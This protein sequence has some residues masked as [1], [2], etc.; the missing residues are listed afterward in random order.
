MKKLWMVLLLAAVLTL[1]GC[2]GGTEEEPQAAQPT[3]TV[4]YVPDPDHELV[5]CWVKTGEFEEGADYVE[6]LT[7]NGDGTL[8]VQLDYR[9]EPYQTLTGTYVISGKHFVVT[10]D[11]D[12]PYTTDYRY[13]VDGREL[14]LSDENGSYVYY[15]E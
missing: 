4:S 5:G 6:T 10:I 9:G 7:V 13:A 14:T 11:A 8:S 2:A 15:S 3:E 12:T 1:A